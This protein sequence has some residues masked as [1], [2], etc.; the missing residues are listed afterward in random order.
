MADDL[1]ILLRSKID[2]SAKS[3]K[4]L[5]AQIK[6]LSSKISELK[7]NIKFDDKVLK[8]LEDSI[9]D[10]QKSAKVNFEID[11][12]K[13]RNVQLKVEKI[14]GKSIKFN[15]DIDSRGIED[16]K[17]RVK[18]V[19]NN[20]DELAKVQINT[21]KNG[22]IKSALITYKNEIGQVVQETLTWQNHLNKTGDLLKRVFTTTNVKY[23]DD[24]EKATKAQEKLNNELLKQQKFVFKKNTQ[25]SGYESDI[26]NL[27]ITKGLNVNNYLNDIT[28]IKSELAQLQTLTVGTT[29]YKTA[30]DSINRM[31]SSLK[32]KINLETQGLNVLKKQED[33]YSRI[34][35][36]LANLK[37]ITIKNE[38]FD[39][40]QYETIATE[41]ERIK[42]AVSNGSMSFAEADS[43]IKKTT[44][45]M[46]DF[47]V[48][49]KRSSN[50]T[51]AFSATFKRFLTY[52]TFYDVIRLGQRA[53]KEMVGTIYELDNALVELR[54]VSDLTGNSLNSFVNDAYRLGSQISKSGKEV[55]QA[56]TEFAKAGYNDDEILGLAKSALVLTSIGDGIKNVGESASTI[57]SVLKGFGKSTG[58]VTSILD[59]IN[60]VSNNSAQSFENITFA[61]QRMSGVMHA[62]NVTLEDS[63]GMFVAINEVLRNSEMSSTALNT[64]SMRIRGLSEDGEAI[65]GLV[66]KLE[67]MYKSF[68]GINLTDTTTGQLKSLSEVTKELYPIWGK[69]SE[70]Q[71]QYIA[72]ETAGIRQ[73]KAFL[74]LMN[75]YNRVLEVTDLA[76]DSAG[77]AMQEFEKWQDSL[78]GKT[79]N[80]RSAFEQLTT[81]TLNSDFVKAMVDATTS[82]VEFITA[83]GGAVPVII[84]LG[85]ALTGLKLVSLIKN[86][87]N[88][89][90]V[91]LTLITAIKSF[92][93]IKFLSIIG[94]ISTAIIGIAYAFNSV[95]NS[96]E[97]AL[98][99]TRENIESLNKEISDINTNKSN[100]QSL[101][102]EFEE[103][104]KN[105]NKNAEETE[106]Y[107]KVQS[108][109]KSILPSLN[110]YYNE[111]GD[112]ILSNA[113]S[114]EDLNEQ[115]KIYLQQKKE[116]LALESKSSA[117][118][119]VEKYNNLKAEL[120]GLTEYINLYNKRESGTLTTDEKDRWS[121]IVLN[122]SQNF[123]K[124]KEKLKEVK[125][126]FNS[127]SSQVR[128]DVLNIV[129][130]TKEWTSA[131]EQQKN[132]IREALSKTSVDYMSSWSEGLA[133]GT[134]TMDDFMLSM[135]VLIPNLKELGD[136]TEQS[137]D[138][139]GK[140]FEELSKRIEK[141]NAVSSDMNK[142]NSI[143]T[144]LNKNGALTSSE[145]SELLGI[146]EDFVSV[147]NDES[148]LRDK[149]NTT[150]EDYK[151]K[152][153]QAYYEM[154]KDSTDYYDKLVNGNVGVYNE[155]LKKLQKHID[156]KG[157]GYTVDL[158]NYKTIEEAKL[159]I[160]KD[161][162]TEIAGIWSK[163]FNST[164][165]AFQNITEQEW[166]SLSDKEKIRLGNMRKTIA[167]LV[168][169]LN[170]EFKGV[171]L[172]SFD[173]KLD[174]DI[175][176]KSS[177]KDSILKLYEERK[178]AIEHEIFLSKQLQS[179]YK[180][181]SKEYLAEADKQA[182]K[183][184][185][186]QNLAS[187]TKINLGLS[188]TSSEGM[189]L[190]QDWWS[191]YNSETSVYQDKLDSMTATYEEQNQLLEDRIRLLEIEQSK[192]E[193]TDPQ[194]RAIEEEKYSLILA[195]QDLL[196][197]KLDEIRKSNV[198][199][200]EEEY[201]ELSKKI[202]DLYE[203]EISSV[204]TIKVFDTEALKLESDNIKKV[205]ESYSKLQGYYAQ[206][207]KRQMNETKKMYQDELKQ[208]NDV[209][210]AKKDAINKE[211]QEKQDKRA[212][213][214]KTKAIT[215]IQDEM[216]LIKN[217]ET[218][219]AR[220][221]ELQEELVKARQDLTDEQDDQKYENR[222]NAIEEEQ[223]RVQEEYEY[224]IQKLEEYIDDEERLKNEFNRKMETNNKALFK[225]L[226]DEAKKYGT[227]TT[228]ELQT[229]WDTC[230]ESLSN[231]NTKQFNINKSFDEMAN[232]LKTIQQ[233][234]KS[235]NSMSINDYSN[236]LP[237]GNIKGGTS[238]AIIPKHHTGLYAG[239]VGGSQYQTKSMEQ[240]TKLLK[241]ELVINAPQAD[242]FMK[243]IAPNIAQSTNGI[244]IQQG[245]IYV[246]GDVSNEKID[247]LKGM[248]IQQRKD[249]LND[250]KK[251]AGG[252]KG[253]TPNFGKLSI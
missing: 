4:K 35:K 215:D 251:I 85:V 166:D 237:A 34:D 127:T 107:Y 214:E 213:D 9:K 133:N 73:A 194:N 151:S 169:G 124:V 130:D 149:L 84:A 138:D 46:K 59:T 159:K 177:A 25:L 200:W 170:E 37:D 78:E 24:I 185:E 26:N 225:S 2:D 146:S 223:K 174:S 150:L 218:Q 82:M 182:K 221:L 72:Q 187:S 66:P 244:T 125:E 94:L 154:I 126:E 184:K 74:T 10:L 211:R 228:E 161:L 14:F 145:I 147:L 135:R 97:E 224:K 219:I 205:Q 80:L 58:E 249:I 157:V 39:T 248:M 81:K 113:T 156:D 173:V 104:S 90:G 67:K 204:K 243:E 61:L 186:L 115:L 155:L 122:Y 178:K 22:G 57:I 109:L 75:N 165:G 246:S 20:I 41:F 230:T 117:G 100:F 53:I 70:N 114:Y 95:K 220:Y 50:T 18:D 69:L 128:S 103:L 175:G 15:P 86:I 158:K 116:E 29:G 88:L 7:L 108:D 140:A 222:I 209:S 52:F 180:E 235:I 17:Q 31:T 92:G 250:F 245:D 76:Y 102:N 1:G 118:A 105:T 99:K 197:K 45:S 106:R 164:T 43:N 89:T 36:Q 226:M 176:G 139:T 142:I 121:E 110:G 87:E 44:V 162:I 40:T 192:L 47:E 27:S 247:E 207:R 148:A 179:T 137:G 54:K 65:D 6:S 195:Q 172:D 32:E 63:V 153:K 171:T 199:G 212:I 8:R 91:T 232:R 229:T 48:Q 62:S 198:K 253:M 203:K 196:Q 190:S 111:Q 19:K 5:N 210:N 231:F 60:N 236:K 163:Y 13:I 227:F 143:F 79:N 96:A 11:D 129:S 167:D 42:S 144:S 168:N 234:I 101:A 191:A 240:L 16:L 188:S 51:N 183:Y 242:K 132:A 119:T 83:C 131:T 68:T 152:H 55:I 28:K 217:D 77:S 233:L 12:S 30:E 33:L 241:G 93:A 49:A 23:V 56:S 123:D 120:E 206:M 98:A 141:F 112:F 216:S 201:K 136:V 239:V 21:T 193:D 71:K 181:T 134:L 189:Q 208:I 38:K 160:T 238:K 202:V 252:N 3:V 64:I